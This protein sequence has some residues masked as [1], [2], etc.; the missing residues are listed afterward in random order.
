MRELQSGPGASPAPAKTQT[1]PAP[2]AKPEPVVSSSA[3]APAPEFKPK[4]EKHP[5]ASPAATI[6]PSEIAPPPLSADK[7]QRLK[8]LLRKYQADEIT[9][10][11]YQK[12]RAKILAEP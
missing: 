4:P 1:P 9:P 7:D 11:Q 12:E 5:S 6:P 3:P 2:P 10:D 8:D